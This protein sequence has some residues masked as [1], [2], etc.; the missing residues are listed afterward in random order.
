M[1]MRLFP[2]TLTLRARLT[3]W[4]GLVLVV[5]LGVSG[6]AVFWMNGRLGVNRVD[7]QLADVEATV[8]KI[9]TNELRE[10]VLPPAA[11]AEASETVSD[12]NV[13]VAISDAHGATLASSLP[14]LDLF[15]T[16]A[17]A[18][19]PMVSTV[20]TSTGTWRLRARRDRVDGTVFVVVVA[21]SLS[22]LAREQ[23]ELRKAMLIG[24]P[25]VLLL[26]GMGGWWLASIGLAALT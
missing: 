23:R 9:L 26:A 13:A 21:I 18:Q 19:E 24:M 22:D 3:W 25:I 8:L 15:R 6:V 14:G 10:Q 2:T 16:I 11:A 20:Y 17:L 1:A 7:G 4:Y 5:V 12:R